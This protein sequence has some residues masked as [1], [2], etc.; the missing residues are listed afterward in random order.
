MKINSSERLTYQ[1]MTV[2]NAELLFQLDQDAE[3]MRYINGGKMTSMEDIE[4]KFLP[5]LQSFTDE[6]EGWGLWKVTVAKTKDFIGWILI[7][8]M[9]FFCKTIQ[10]DNLE[11]GWR[12][13]RWS[14]GKGYASEAAKHVMTT[15]IER[16]EKNKLRKFSAIAIEANK[17]S[18]YIM[19]K[20]GMNYV[21]TEFCDAP[22][23]NADVV[24]YELDI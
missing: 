8:P 19:L 2:D 1:L 12:F 3:V 10:F 24:F 15:I 20:L 14:W 4:N 18:I 17:A 21:K 6:Q 11:I 7:R 5:R 13:H 23:V 16:D 22:L 9:D